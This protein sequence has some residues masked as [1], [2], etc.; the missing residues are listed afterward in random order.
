[1]VSV[2]TFVHST[3]RAPLVVIA[4]AYWSLCR[5]PEMKRQ[6]IAATAIISS[7]LLVAG[8][9]IAAE[10]KWALKSLSGISFSE[11]KG[12]D[13]WAMIGSSQPDDASGC[14]T[15]PAPGCIKSI[16][17]NAALV[18]AYKAGIPDNGKPVP[19]GAAFAKIEWAKARQTVP[20]GVTLPGN[21]AEVSFMLKDSQR[22][23]KTNGWGYATFQYDA[24]TDTW[25]SK[26]DNPD[27]VNAC[28]GC[29]TVVKT[30]DWVFTH[31][32]KR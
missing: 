29:H 17:G 26:G 30:R 22:F 18:K 32:A 10:D 6:H 19:D 25:T 14:G 2:D 4:R 28:H 21:L 15:S 27:F 11:F 1:M 24:K 20:Y 9:G 16:V 7:S 31:F 3:G 23:P 5:S 13:S 8:S 12:Y